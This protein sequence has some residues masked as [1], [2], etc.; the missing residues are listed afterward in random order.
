MRTTL[1]LDDDVVA[2]LNRERARSKRPFRQVVNEALRAGLTRT[3]QAKRRVEPY[4]T[5]AVSL[6]RCLLP[7][8]D[9]VEQILA[10]VEGEGHR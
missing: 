2:L 10:I 4:R 1:T 7:N 5:Q 8:L 6:G 9:N 3:V